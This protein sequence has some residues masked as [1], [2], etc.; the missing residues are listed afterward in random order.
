[1]AVNTRENKFIRFGSICRV[2]L[3][4][5]VETRVEENRQSDR[6]NKLFVLLEKI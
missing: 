1:M 3:E 2:S 4:K 5:I 6:P